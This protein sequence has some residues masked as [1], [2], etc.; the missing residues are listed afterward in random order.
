[1]SSCTC[2]I[3]R[4]LLSWPRKD[5]ALAVKIST[6]CASNKSY[7][8]NPTSQHLQCKAKNK[9]DGCW[10][11]SMTRQQ[12]QQQVSIIQVKMKGQRLME[13]QVKG[14]GKQATGKSQEAAD[15]C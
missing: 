2:W 8:N 9:K 15:A 11:I 6:V 5:Q 3:K 10:L 14:Y 7:H 1:M 4:A 13:A 12:K